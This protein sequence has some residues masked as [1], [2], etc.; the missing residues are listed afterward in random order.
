MQDL[1]AAV[2]QSREC[3]IFKHILSIFLEKVIL[4]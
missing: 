4:T 1:Q 3:W 2:V